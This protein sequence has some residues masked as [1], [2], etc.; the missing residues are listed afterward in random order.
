ML[1]RDKLNIIKA[2]TGS[3]KTYFAF[4][5][6][7]E[8]VDDA[9]HKTVYLIDTVNGK[10]QILNNYNASVVSSYWME[11]VSENEMERFYSSKIVVIT[12]AKFGLLTLK[13]LTFPNHF[14]YIIC[15]E[16]PS[17]PK[18]ESYSRGTNNHTV[19][20]SAIESAV[21]N[22]RTKVI[23]LSATPNSIPDAFKVPTY[24]L[25]ID[26]SA[27]RR[28][29]TKEVIRYNDIYSLL[30]TMNPAETGICYTY[31]IHTMK[32]LEALARKSGLNPI[33]IWSINNPDHEMNAEQLAVRRS[34]L[35]LFRL[36][37]QYN[38]LIINASSET[39][40]KIKTPIDYVI[41]NSPDEDTQIQV[42]GRVNNDLPKIYLPN[43]DLTSIEVPGRFLGRELFKKDK[44]ELCK[45]FNRRNS[46][47]RLCKWTTIRK[48]LEKN[49][50]IVRDGRRKNFRFT[51][52]ELPE[53]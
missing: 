35:E 8:A 50:Y 36:P 39:S 48:L 5:A 31:H 46:S 23:A 14:D 51:I 45:I 27:V 47:N 15:D 17:L 33:C 44:D 38:L 1:Q 6:I 3:G 11:E 22:D 21:R 7:P 42:R 16:L 34:I 2:P 40:I 30:P 29:E 24:Q 10:E 4:K 9:Y 20:I 12:Y 37:P 13:D 25:P 53:L 52:I 32:K 41:V 19:A 43:D 26:E 28:Y 18:F 49:E